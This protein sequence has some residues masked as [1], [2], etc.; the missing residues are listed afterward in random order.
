MMLM[1]NVVRL[2]VRVLAVRVSG[3]R[4]GDDA[5]RG[6]PAFSKTNGRAMQVRGPKAS[7][8]QVRRKEW[9]CVMYY[10]IQDLE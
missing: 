2:C 10:Y 4:D 7:R 8:P 6:A 9:L 1:Q 3:H 5:D